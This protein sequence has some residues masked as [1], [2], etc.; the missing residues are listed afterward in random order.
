MIATNKSLKSIYNLV[1]KMRCTN[2][3]IQKLFNE[4]IKSKELV[5]YKNLIE[6]NMFKNQINMLMIAYH[7][8]ITSNQKSD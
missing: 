7:S 4:K 2:Q 8:M 1:E 5:F 6:R 3:K